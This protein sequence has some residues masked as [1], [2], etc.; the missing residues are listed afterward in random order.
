MGR[1]TCSVTFRPS[2]QEVVVL[3]GA[4]LVEAAGRAGIPLEQPCGGAGKCGRCRIEVHKGAPEPSDADRKLLDSEEL[5]SRVRLA[6]QTTVTDDMVV[7]V[8]MESRLFEQHALTQGRTRH[9]GLDPHVRKRVVDMTNL[10]AD[11]STSYAD[12]LKAALRADDEDLGL[13]VDGARELSPLIMAEDGPATALLRGNT[14]EAVEAGDTSEDIWG[15]A[16]DV[17]TTTVAGALVNLSN[18]AEGAVTGRSNP[19]ANYG[20]DVVDRIG[21]VDEQE[22]GLED[23]NGCIIE[24]LND[25]LAEMAESAGADLDSLHEIVAVGNTTM[26]HLLLDIDPT[27]LAHAPYLAVLR[28]SADVPAAELG[29]RAAPG[30]RLHA[31]PNVAGFVGSDTVG[32]VLAT[33][34][35]ESEEVQLAVD[36]GTN[37]EVVVGNRDRLIGCSCAAGPAFEGARIRHGMRAADGAVTKVV[38]NDDIDVNVLGGGPARGICGSGLVDAVAELLGAGV[39]EE[40]GRIRKREEL[41]RSVPEAVRGAVMEV[42]GEQAVALVEEDR[43]ETDGPLLLYQEDLRELQLGKAAVRAGIEVACRRYGIDVSDLDRLL[44]AGGFGNFIRRSSA[45]RI[46]LLPDIPSEKLESVGNA[47]FAGARMSLL[48]RSCRAEADRV[49]SDIEYEELARSAEFQQ[50]YTECMML[51]PNPALSTA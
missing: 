40:S 37:G 22:N 16:F 46:G 49:S 9:F 18:G 21:Y 3:E 23:L 15:A 1:K 12:W 20:D 34:L 24:L 33:G 42:D 7:S 13:A 35:A 43:S 32:V 6:C 14:V 38:I 5:E 50:A 48:C 41:P 26:N 25:M 39:I 19:Q 45:K 51:G 2:G 28:E 4:G 17:G 31:L 10:D 47:A 11:D 29:L 30:A 27:P 44:V 8:P 36:I